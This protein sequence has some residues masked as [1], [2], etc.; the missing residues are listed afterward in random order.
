V[1]SGCKW[2]Q[3][4]KQLLYRSFQQAGADRLVWKLDSGRLRILCY[5]GI[6]EDHA[7]NEPWVP[8]F[9]VTRSAFDSQLQYLRRCSNILPL[10]EASMRLQDGSLPP[11]SVSITFDDGYANNLHLAYPLLRKYGLQATIFLSSSYIESGE[12]FPFL[13]L[14]LIRLK[15]GA[16]LP[17][18]ALPDY[19]LSALDAVMRQAERWW[20]DIESQVDEDQRRTLRPLTREEVRSMDSSTI[21]FGAHCHT[22]CILRNETAERR[23]QEIETSISRVA[24]LSGKRVRLFSYPN[25]QRGDFNEADKQ[26]LRARSIAAAVSGISGANSR[27]TEALELRRYP[28]GLFHDEAG[29]RA[30]V[31]G[32]RSVVLQATQRLG[33]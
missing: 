32:F 25:G 10:S 1:C 21:E 19:K 24:Q 11:R 6:C 31:T 7:V 13:K 14:K 9:F 27:G 29:F 5:H 8:Q 15:A 18:A 23:R 17:T 4:L 12:F 28:V 16:G 26:V 30:E 20:P 2:R 33:A 22:H 3:D